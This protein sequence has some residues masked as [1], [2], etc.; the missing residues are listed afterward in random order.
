[1]GTYYRA[2]TRRTTN[3][4]IRIHA[5][6]P[7]T[8]AMIGTISVSSLG[9]TAVGRERERERWREGGREEKH[10][11]EGGRGEEH[12][13]EGVANTMSMQAQHSLIHLLVVGDIGVLSLNTLLSC[14]EL[15]AVFYF[16]IIVSFIIHFL[17]VRGRL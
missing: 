3:T 8:P 11:R 5:R 17:V 4:I 13:R 10:V 9:K 15:L 1:M 16:C 14:R 7:I 6:A 12:V 2:T